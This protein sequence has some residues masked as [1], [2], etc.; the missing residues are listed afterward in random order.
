VTNPSLH[1][2]AES[3][4]APVELVQAGESGLLG[5]HVIFFCMSLAV[6]GMSFLMQAQGQSS[7]YLPGSSHALPEL[8]MAKRV[9]GVPCPGCGLTRS[10]VSISHGQ[11]SRA[12]AFNPTSFLLYPFVFV[13]IPWHAMQ[14]WLIRKRGYGA[15]LPHIH[16]LPIV[17]AII[18]LV[19]WLIRMPQLVS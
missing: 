1:Q 18:L 19:Q 2:D 6:I 3:S 10:F 4:L 12:W 16:F 5:L 11:F 15:H 7:V 9:F 17:I 14:F 8:C 13:Q